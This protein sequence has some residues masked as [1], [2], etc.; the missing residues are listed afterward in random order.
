MTIDPSLYPDNWNEISFRIRFERAKG[1]CEWCGAPHGKAIMR[2]TVDPF[3]YLWEDD[4]DGEMIWTTPAGEQVKF[5]EIPDEFDWEKITTVWLTVHHVGIDKPDGTPGDRE[6]KMDCRDENLAAL[7][8]R[9]HLLA[10]IDL[11]IAKRHVT[12]LRRKH[13]TARAAG[14]LVLLEDIS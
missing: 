13:E 11:H 7:C 2:S 4:T 6:D 14:Q 5:S 10:D 12:L 9:C 1:R 3:R 8:Q